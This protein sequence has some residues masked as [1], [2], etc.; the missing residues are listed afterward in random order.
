V[1]DHPESATA[2]RALLERRGLGVVTARSAEKALELFSPDAFDVILTD[3]RLGEMS[4]VDL[5]REI[6]GTLPEFPVILITGFDSLQSAI[7]AVKFGAQ[8]YILKPVDSIEEVLLPI[9]NAVE[10]PRVIR[11]RHDYGEVSLAC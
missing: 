4:G 6:R 8:D 9:R 2:M 5:L 7:A 10:S 3:I 11:S 1:E